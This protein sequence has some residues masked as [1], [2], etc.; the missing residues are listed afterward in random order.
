MIFFSDYFDQLLNVHNHAED[1][2]LATL[3]QVSVEKPAFQGLG[4]PPTL[5]E[6]RDTIHRLKPRKAAGED[7]IISEALVLGGEVLWEAIWD[8]SHTIWEKEEVPEEWGGGLLVPLFKSGPKENP[9]NYRGIALLNVTSKVLT[10]ILSVA[11][12]R[13]NSSSNK[14]VFGLA[15]GPQ[16]NSSASGRSSK[17]TSSTTNHFTW[18]LW[19]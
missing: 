4:L 5:E 10:C 2:F 17:S 6:V 11:L 14:L 19:I 7:E 13:K 8:L 16:I 12:W 9:D 15:E 18:P 3:K 1:D